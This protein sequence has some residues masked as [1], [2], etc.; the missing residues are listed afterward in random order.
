MGWGLR[1]ILRTD[2]RVQLIRGLSTTAVYVQ[3]CVHSSVDA[4]VTETFQICTLWFLTVFC[5]VERLWQ[6]TGSKL[7]YLSV[8][9][10]A[11][12][13]PPV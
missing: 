10:A 6:E 9:E 1:D 13:R 8:L 12:K 4:E 5:Y 7:S 2:A 3:E 11:V